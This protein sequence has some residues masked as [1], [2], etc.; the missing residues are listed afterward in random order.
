MSLGLLSSTSPC[1]GI[2][3]LRVYLLSWENMW[4]LRSTV[5][6]WFSKQRVWFYDWQK[7]LF[8]HWH[9]YQYSTSSEKYYFSN[10]CWTFLRQKG[11]YGIKSLSQSLLPVASVH[12]KNESAS[13]EACREARLIMTVPYYM[14]PVSADGWRHKRASVSLFKVWP[15]QEQSRMGKPELCLYED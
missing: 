3:P 5:I 1:A 12:G 15:S 11:V 10:N 13:V 7:M 4:Q 8:A 6:C 9:P 14:S 2:V